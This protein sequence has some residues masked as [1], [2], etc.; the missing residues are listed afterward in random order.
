MPPNPSLHGCAF[1]LKSLA[2]GVRIYP[3]HIRLPHRIFREAYACYMQ[4]YAGTLSRYPP[5]HAFSTRLQPKQF[6]HTSM[7]H[8]PAPHHFVIP[9]SS[10]T[11][12]LP[13]ASFAICACSATQ[14]LP[15]DTRVSGSNVDGESHR[16]PTSTAHVCP[17]QITPPLT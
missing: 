1:P 9:N 8:P 11:S 6:L 10:I 7:R 4:L 12:G 2:P 3:E 5:M 16:T 14:R 15:Q 13:I 17:I